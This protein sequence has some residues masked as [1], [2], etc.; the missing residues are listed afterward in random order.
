MK[1]PGLSKVLLA[2]GALLL[3]GFALLAPRLPA[4]VRSKANPTSVEARLAQAV[5]L[6]EEGKEPMR[7]IAMLQEILSE[8][9]LNIEAHWHLAQF[10]VVSGQFDKAAA[11]FETV[12]ALDGDRRFPDAWFYL[13]R[14]YA[15]LGDTANAISALNK[16]KTLSTDTAILRGVDRFIQDLSINQE[17]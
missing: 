14:T 4:N 7:G 11:R 1:G 8:D 13:G 12:V 16:Y 3:F 5:H 9:S 6:V 17:N 10:S 15:T 2:G